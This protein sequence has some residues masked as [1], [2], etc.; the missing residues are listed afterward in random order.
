MAQTF[1][2][3]QLRTRRNHDN[4]L[5]NDMRS[6]ADEIGRIV[7]RASKLPDL[8]V[9]NTFERRDFIKRS[10]W[11]QVIR[12]YFIGNNDD[13]FNGMRPQSPYA[14]LL[15]SGI[16]EATA[17]AVDQQIAA[18]R[19]VVKDEVVW[20]WLTG[21][22][23]F[24]VQE[25]VYDPFHRFVDPNGYTLSDRVWRT[26][27]S[28]RS[29][30]DLLL[31]YH[32][33]RGTSAV[34]IAELLEDFLTPGTK[35]IKTRTPY[36]REGSYAARRLARTEITAAAGRGVVNASQANPFVDGIRWRLSASHPKFDICDIHASG[37][38]NGDGVYSPGN[39]P[40]YPPHPHC[41]CSLLPVPVGNTADLVKELRADIQ[42]GTAVNPLR[43]ILNREWLIGAI[44]SGTISKVLE[45]IA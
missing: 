12:P 24:N 29:R 25:M 2:S 3:R 27:I 8:T 37:G 33:S 20:F 34:K 38:D 19:R 13:P 10:I 17:T 26:S 45:A 5:T 30:I 31:D 9:P 1:A 11:T 7:T 40:T 16:E 42:S 23:P 15:Y 14:T 22:R 32:I 41:L 4:R 36:G 44:L 28:V 43:G 35:S 39:V 6:I 21:S 18:V